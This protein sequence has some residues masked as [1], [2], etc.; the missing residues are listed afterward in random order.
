MGYC[1]GSEIFQKVME[2]F[3]ARPKTKAKGI[4]DES[5]TKIRGT[6][7][8]MKKNVLDFND[9]KASCFDRVHEL[10]GRGVSVQ[11]ISAV[12]ADPGWPFCL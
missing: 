6:V 8:L 4:V 9:I 7:V 1:P 3:C 11:L 5:K 10:L 2:K 12:H